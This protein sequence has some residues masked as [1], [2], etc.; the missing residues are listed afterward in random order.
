MEG[1]ED[2]K[3]QVEHITCWLIYGHCYPL[4]VYTVYIINSST[5]SVTVLIKVTK[6]L[7]LR[8]ALR[9]LPSSSQLR[10]VFDYGGMFGAS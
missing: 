3:Q 6:H 1:R 7:C 8:P 9:F 4:F 10:K 5:A 2:F